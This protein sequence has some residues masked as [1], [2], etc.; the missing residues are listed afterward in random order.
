MSSIP[1]SSPQPPRNKHRRLSHSR[2]HKMER[3][4]CHHSH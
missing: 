3:M 2:K 1:L 4:K